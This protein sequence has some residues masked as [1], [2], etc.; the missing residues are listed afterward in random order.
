MKLYQLNKMC[1]S[2]TMFPCMLPIGDQ[3]D[4]RRGTL[5]QVGDLGPEVHMGQKKKFVILGLTDKLIWMIF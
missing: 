5:L 3:G 2:L 1:S 4:L